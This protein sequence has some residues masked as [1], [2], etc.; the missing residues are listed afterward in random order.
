MYFPLAAVGSL[1]VASNSVLAAPVAEAS[2]GLQKRWEY[3]KYFNLEGHRGARGQMVEATLP[4]FAESLKSGVTT[5]EL[6]VSLTASD[7]LLV[8]HDEKVDPTKCIDT[9]PVS[10]D[11][12]QFPYVGKNLAN[13]TVEQIQTLDCGSL[14]LDGFPLALTR[15]NT[16]L[17]TLEQLF[18]FVDCATDEPVLFNIESKI[19]GDHHNE[20]RSP[21][22]FV[23][24][25]KAILEPR[26]EGFIDRITHQSFDWRAIIE[27]KKVM[28]SLRTSAL[29]DDTTI[30]A[31]PE[32]ETTGNLT[33]HGNGPSNWLAGIDID[34][35]PGSTPQ[36][37]VAQAAASINADILSPVATSYASNVTD[38][39]M[40]GFIPF[41]TKAMVD[42]AKKLGMKVEPW[43]PNRLNLI[44][45]LVKD[46]GVTGIITDYPRV[47]H[48]WL[49]AEGYNVPKLPGKK[50]IKRIDRCLE[51]HLVL[52]KH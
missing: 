36:E 7:K 27:S 34:S 46:C 23:A 18:D 35:F 45:Y 22:D 52:T 12:E 38:V 17:S 20:T 31:Y 44:E 25:F 32:G 5:L 19:N 40:P 33:V 9:T 26:G 16:T 24:A 2:S 8:W 37:R 39:N 3:S 48:D 49:V 50:E 1:L 4:A 15:P 29:C 14:R 42:E 6:D 10:P 28:P 41:T 43:T 30:W 11:D 21:E 13:L 47:A 51:K